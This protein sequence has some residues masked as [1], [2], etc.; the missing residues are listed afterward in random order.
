MIFKTF[1][2]RFVFV[3]S[4]LVALLI[5]VFASFIYYSYSKALIE[6]LDKAL[7]SVAKKGSAGEAASDPNI[8]VELLKIV[9]ND[10]YQVITR[11]G[12]VTIAYLGS[13]YPWPVNRRLIDSALKGLPQF[14]TMN[15]KS[16]NFRI[17]YYPVDADTV[18]RA[19][20]SQE[21]F[22]KALAELKRLFLFSFPP[23]LIISLLLGWIFAGR[24]LS[25]V[26]KMKSLAEQIRQGRWDKR[27]TLKS[28]GKEINELGLILNEIIDNIKRSIESQK[29]FTADVSHEIR[30][31]LTSLRGSI[32]VALR[33]K[34]PPEE[35]EEVL[36]NNLS[37]VIRLTRLTD[38]L[39]F[40]SKAENK[41]LALRRQWFDVKRMLG[42]VIE[43]FREKTMVEGLTIIEDY[44][45]ELELNGDIELLEQAF[46]NIIDNGM[47]YTPRGGSITIKCYEEDSFV[48]ILVSDTGIGIP[49]DQ[50]PHI[51]ERFYRVDREHSKR[52]GGTGLGLAITHWIIKA[53]NGEISVTSTV[54]KGT[55]FTIILPKM[56]EI[57][58]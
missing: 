33:K 46:S 26:R 29:R 10:F 56:T 44:Q 18:L 4:A 45:N 40:L 12:K 30:S 16:E 14:E 31:P 43:G 47:K 7:L 57:S 15:Y 21:S 8:S 24:M 48:K 3:S 35:Y 1:R 36:R 28:Q 55:E 22:D 42:S 25:P 41:I 23:L 13:N 50:I 53:H 34:R 11:Q 5:I 19:K 54:D 32:E 6:A 51:F 37:D 58:I 20:K 52:L 17:L 27:L 9:N 2:G 38:N 39:L 49:E